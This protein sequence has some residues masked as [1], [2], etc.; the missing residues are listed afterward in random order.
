MKRGRTA[1]CVVVVGG[2]RIWC[3]EKPSSFP[4]VI[5]M[6]S[7]QIPFRTHADIPYQPVLEPSECTSAPNPQRGCFH[8]QCAS[9]SELHHLSSVES[10]IYFGNRSVELV[11]SISLHQ[12]HE[13]WPM[14]EDSLYQSVPFLDFSR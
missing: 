3:D 4:R 7:S 5:N 9:D 11:Q 8:S 1:N 10:S 13:R 14:R 12:F 6:G 2:D